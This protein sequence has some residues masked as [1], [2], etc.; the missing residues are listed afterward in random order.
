MERTASFFHEH[1]L[2]TLTGRFHRDIDSI[3][4]NLNIRH[5]SIS[6]LVI[7]LLETAIMI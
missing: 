5:A 6:S 1:A 3:L 7:N 4:I 2:A